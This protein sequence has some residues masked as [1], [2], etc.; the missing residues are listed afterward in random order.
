[1]TYIFIVIMAGTLSLFLSLYVQI[2]I[3]DAPGAKSYVIVT[4]LS[5][6]FTFAYAFE[7]ASSTL[8]QMKFWL[9]VEYLA[10]P[11]IP[12]FVLLM[13]LEYVGHKL[14]HWVYY[15][16][17]LIPFT[18][19]FMMQT[20]NLHHLYYTSLNLE[21][22]STSPILKLDWGP[23]FYVHSIFVFLC[24]IISIVVL[25]RQFRNALFMFRMQILLM[26]AGLLTPIIANY[27]YLN[28]W[29]KG[30]DLG[31]VSLS[32]TFL[33]HGV[34]L[35]SLKMF[36]VAPIAR[37]SVF[38]SMKEGVIVINQNQ[39]I[40]DFNQ[41]ALTIIPALSEQQ[42]GK[43]IIEILGNKSSLSE[44][45][46]AEQEC[47]YTMPLDEKVLHY[48]INFSPILNKNGLHVGKIITFIDVTERVNMQ[49][50]LKK[51][52]SLDGL[53]QVLNRTFFMRKSE[54]IMDHLILNGGSIS[55]IM[56]DID[57]FKKIN[58]TF[59][60]E[61]GDLVL[62]QVT[63]TVQEELH[64]TEFMG[65]YG[66]EEFIICMPKTSLAEASARAKSI[67][68]AV[69]ESYTIFNGEKIMVT[70]SFGV[71]NAIVEEGEDRY[72]LSD[73]IR[74]ADMALYT[75]KNNG[76]NCVES[77]EENNIYSYS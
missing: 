36:N 41:A 32:I 2:K 9:S 56:F 6:V 59:G 76:R 37:D 38:E 75:A 3:K 64:N 73:L 40:V 60:H 46:K 11:F 22:T 69:E 24:L 77:Y 66:G 44:K 17:F 5:S 1:M 29:S 55:V 45:I 57:Y 53:T 12:V 21:N 54:M 19:I 25:L 42:I 50:K 14:K 26:V 28:G 74:Q 31:P 27:F 10:M 49:D 13:C 16:L 20:N 34:A 62:T 52:A 30:I 70:S 39:V 65:R 72:S 51:L 48:R 35:I 8:Q 58:D 47:D 18:T 7:L 4:F 33:F 67:R 71:S 23:W 61:A 68:T 43:T 15:V 63:K